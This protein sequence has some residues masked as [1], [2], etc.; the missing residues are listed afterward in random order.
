MAGDIQL[1]DGAMAPLTG[2]MTSAC[3]VAPEHVGR[4]DA[5]VALQVRLACLGLGW[6]TGRVCCRADEVELQV[7]DEVVSRWCHWYAGWEP[8]SF[9][10]HDDR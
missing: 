6:R 7:D 8:S 4:V 2:T 1:S 5:V 10:R 3:L 9:V